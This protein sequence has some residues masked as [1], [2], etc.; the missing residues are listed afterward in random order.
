[1]CFHFHCLSSSGDGVAMAGRQ[2]PKEDPVKIV[3]NITKNM[4]DGFIDD[5]VEKDVFNGEELSKLGDCINTIVKKTENLVTNVTE[6]TQ[7]AGQIFV[8]RFWNPNKQLSLKS[9][10]ESDDA[11]T[12]STRSSSSSAESPNESDHETN[13]EA[14]LAQASLPPVTASL[15]TLEI[16]ELKLC[17]HRRF[18]TVKTE[19][20]Y[21]VMEEEG[22]T[23]LALIICNKVFDH[24][25][26]RHGAEIDILGMQALLEKLGY[27]VV[28]KEN[29][30][31]QQM[32]A[33]LRQFAGRPEHKSSDST[34]LVFMSHGTLDGICGKKHSLQEPDILKDDIIFSIFNNSNCQS[35]KDKPKVIIMQAC[36][37][38][39]PGIV[40][41][42]DMGEAW[43]HPFQCAV[44]NDAITRAHVEK[45]FISFK[46]STPH[47]ISW[48]L[49]T[50]GSLF[51]SR[52]IKCFEEYY[53]CYHLE[54][55]F[56]KVQHSFEVPSEMTQ[57]PTIERVSLTRYFYLLP[58]N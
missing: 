29:L 5:L 54:Q 56:R 19:E 46:A 2:S 51:I 9:R 57:M 13:E 49:D 14:E 39:S 7:K 40:W 25:S 47:N 18:Q 48:R 10:S 42:T 36:R 27:A 20:I 43:A 32:E 6:K 41:M 28:V 23:R 11:E 35:L 24:L 55:I 16:D 38:G 53:R 50:H 4:L 30:T 3:K 8:D 44:Q 12:E 45:D 52:L 21:P 37:G 34:F 31:A 33:E 22:R 1:M 58:G 17:S 26:M 15:E